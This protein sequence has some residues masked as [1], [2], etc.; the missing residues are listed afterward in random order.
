MNHRRFNDKLITPILI[1]QPLT[2]IL[3][4]AYLGHMFDISWF[5]ATCPAEFGGCH[6]TLV[7]TFLDSIFVHR[8]GPSI[9][10]HNS[11]MQKCSLYNQFTIT[12]SHVWTGHKMSS[13]LFFKIHSTLWMI[14]CILN[15]TVGLLKGCQLDARP[16]VHPN[17]I[18]LNKKMAEVGLTHEPCRLRQN[19]VIIHSAVGQYE[20]SVVI[21]NYFWAQEF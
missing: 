9:I 12:F 21:W 19:H 14:T 17:R 7:W 16:T 2:I 6:S 4:K 1:L 20:V 10:A 13:S 11:D 5:E 3:Q 18:S 15:H 8:Y